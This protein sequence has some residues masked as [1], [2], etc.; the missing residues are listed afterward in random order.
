MYTLTERVRLDQCFSILFHTHTY[1]WP[2]QH[3]FPKSI[4][5]PLTP[6]Q[7]KKIIR[8]NCNNRRNIVNNVCRKSN[9]AFPPSP[10]ISTK[11][12]Q[13][14]PP[15]YKLFL[16]LNNTSML[17]I[18]CIHSYKTFE[19]IQIKLFSAITLFIEY[20]SYPLSYPPWVL[21]PPPEKRCSRWKKLVR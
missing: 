5:S 18:Y 4:K 16:V 10:E 13:R 8:Q 20:S 2:F 9:L 11:Y 19:M 15:I 1:I 3:C 17:N 14:V 21:V 12:L 7:K 6:P